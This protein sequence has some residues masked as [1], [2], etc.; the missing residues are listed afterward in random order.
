MKVPP[1]LCVIFVALLAAADLDIRGFPHDSLRTERTWE[2]KA[3]AGIQPG[4]IRQYMEHIAVRPHLAGSPASKAVADYIAGLLRSWGLN[5]RIEEFQVLLP[6]PTVRS[7][8]MIEPHKI[9]AS[10]QEPPVED[11]QVYLRQWPDSAL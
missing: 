4:Q 6:T 11:D 8:E 9:V 7:L 5:V 3:R 10:L 1:G 2:D